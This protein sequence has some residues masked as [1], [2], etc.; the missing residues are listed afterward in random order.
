MTLAFF[1][2]IT[3]SLIVAL[4]AIHSVNGIPAN[5]F[6]LFIAFIVALTLL[7]L[8]CFL[9]YKRYF[10]KF[11]HIIALLLYFIQEFLRANFSLAYEIITP[12]NRL[13]PAVIAL[14]LDITTDLE[15]LLFANLITLTPG[16]LTLDISEDKKTLFVHAIF[17]KEQNIKK[18]KDSLKNGFERKIL[19]ITK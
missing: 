1:I 7:W 14:P 11:P 9:L 5:T 15:I 18:L 16:T 13:E 10:T 17:V 19:K 2:H 3:L 4:A 12:G 8:L 6:T